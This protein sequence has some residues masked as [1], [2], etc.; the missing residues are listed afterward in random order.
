MIRAGSGRI[1]SQVSNFVWVGSGHNSVIL[2]GSGQGSVFWLGRVRS[3]VSNTDWVSLVTGSGHWVKTLDAV[4]T[5]LFTVDLHDRVNKTDPN[6][7]TVCSTIHVM[8]I[9]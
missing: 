7:N 5:Q 2:S 9:E 8:L 4:S 6:V 1:R 3:R